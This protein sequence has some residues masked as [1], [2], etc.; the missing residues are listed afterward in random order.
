MIRIAVAFL[1]VVLSSTSSFAQQIPEFPKPTKEH[2]WLN[3]FVGE[4]EAESEC[5]PVPGGP[6]MKGK[7][8][9]KVHSI[10][11]FWIVSEGDAEMAGM[12]MHMQMTVGYSPEKKKYIGTWVD[13]SNA[14][15]WHYE[16]TVEGNT[17]TLEASGPS[18]LNPKVTTKYRD[19]TEFKGADERV[20][21]SFMQNEKGEWVKM[22]TGR[23][24]RKK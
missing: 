4:W 8:Q 5:T 15:L 17:L 23:A 12:K 3:R 1:A 13:S 10:G 2:E 11:G 22:V 14:H 6:V 7:M 19:V 18:M 21:T 9:E 24:T 20:M 16:G